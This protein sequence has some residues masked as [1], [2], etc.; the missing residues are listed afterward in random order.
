[1]AK[2][3]NAEG[4]IVKDRRT[5]G[6]F[7]TQN[8][9]IDGWLNKMGPYTYA[10]YA[11]LV[12]HSAREDDSC[13]LYQNSIAI[14]GGMSRRQVNRAVNF[15]VKWRLVTTKQEKRND[16]GHKHLTYYLVDPPDPPTT[17]PCGKDDTPCDCESQ[18]G[19]KPDSPIP[20]DT[21][22]HP[23][24]TGRRNKNKTHE[25][26]R[27]NEQELCSLDLCSLKK[28]QV[29]SARAL[30]DSLDVAKLTNVALIGGMAAL[31]ATDRLEAKSPLKKGRLATWRW[32]LKNPSA[33]TQADEDRATAAI[34][35]LRG[36]A[37]DGSLADEPE[38]LGDILE[39][40]TWLGNRGAG[41]RSETTG[42]T[43][44]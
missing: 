32:F 26:T 29:S 12:R 8:S 44:G 3:K 24:E 17:W 27:P 39:G 30:W 36:E 4:C 38:T 13:Y 21:K 1:M 28:E 37:R 18:G 20:S 11:I 42:R 23:P 43:T 5:R 2:D 33:I 25:G 15:L 22:S 34:R 7:I 10:V 9:V 41:R 31:F 6:F 16:G 40:A 14:K 35:E 19:G